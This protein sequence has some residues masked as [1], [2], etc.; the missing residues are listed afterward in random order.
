MLDG[1][2]CGAAGE[3]QVGKGP[4]SDGFA[5]MS[6]EPAD[7]N[8]VIVREFQKRPRARVKPGKRGRIIA[9]ARRLRHRDSPAGIKPA[10][11]VYLNHYGCSV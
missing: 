1:L 9:A 4:I 11:N 3:C 10:S 7:R 6:E 5:A 2:G 8:S